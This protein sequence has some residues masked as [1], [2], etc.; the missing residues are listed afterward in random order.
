MD[1]GEWIL[2]NSNIFSSQF[3]LD[4]NHMSS[5]LEETVPE[6]YMYPLFSIL[7]N[8][9]LHMDTCNTDNNHNT[10]AMSIRES[11]ECNN[12]DSNNNLDFIHK[13]QKQ[14]DIISL[15]QSSIYKTKSIESLSNPSLSDSKDYQITKIREKAHQICTLLPIYKYDRVF[16]I[17]Y[18]NRYAENYIEL[19][20]WD[21]LPMKRP[22]IKIS[23]NMKFVDDNSVKCE[24][25]FYVYGR[26]RTSSMKQI[27]DLLSMQ[28][29]SNN[30]NTKSK[31]TVL[32]TR[33]TGN[34][35][36]NFGQLLHN[37][38]QYLS[39]RENIKK[40]KLSAIYK[41]K[42]LK[43]PTKMLEISNVDLSNIKPYRVNFSDSSS[44]NKR[45]VNKTIIS[46]KNTSP[47]IS[48]RSKSTLCD[49]VTSDVSVAVTKSQ[50]S[51]ENIE[52][53]PSTSTGIYS[54]QNTKHVFGGTRKKDIK[55]LK[56]TS[57]SKKD[58]DIENTRIPL[59]MELDKRLEFIFPDLDKN[60]IN[61]LCIRYS[62]TDLSLD[63]QFEE[64]INII[65]EDRQV[66]PVEI[67]SKINQEKDYDIDE[68]YNYL[69]E[70]FPNA[71]PAYLKKV[72][73][74]TANDPAKL[75]QFIEDQC[76]CPTY[77]TKDE[78]I[79]RMHI[80]EQQMLY[81]R[82]FDVRQ[83]LEIYPSPHTYFEDPERK[84]E[85]NPDALEFLKHHFNKFEVETLM[86]VYEQHNYH[87]TITANALENMK[88]DKKTNYTTMWDK[89]LSDDIS[90]LHECAFI[91]HKN[92]ITEYQKELKKREDEEFEELQKRNELLICQCCYVNCIPSKCSTCDDG[93]VFCN[94]CIVRGTQTQIA[95]GN[96][97]VPCFV[98]CD[99][100]F[101]L[102]TLQKVLTPMQFSIFVRKMQEREVMSAGI[103]GLVSCPFCQFASIPPL[104]DNVFKCLNPECMK[105]SCRLCKEI[106]HI[107]LKCYEEK[108]EKARLFLEEKMTE[109]LVH[110]CHR[111]S[112]PYFKENGCN[113]ITCVCGC[114]M[115][116]LCD[117]EITG[118]EHF[119]K[120]ICS[121][122]SD[123][124]SLNAAAV[125]AVAEKTMKYIEEKD[126][127]IKINADIIFPN[128][129]YNYSEA[130]NQ[131]IQKR[132]DN[133]TR[134]A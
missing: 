62:N 34:N 43:N 50:D 111:C 126:P 83:F 89:T 4:N 63:K 37:Y 85:Y 13:S 52:V 128:I 90:L 132:V 106:N 38:M 48:P 6:S 82:E 28:Y 96:V 59:R 120:G 78:K 134:F 2:S 67:N 47:D 74:R 46:S 17:L 55:F 35:S 5:S 44:T 18:K 97:H 131:L 121:L 91:K 129:Q 9:E 119:N 57:E 84:H 101:R 30:S 81:I 70:I 80:T 98:D 99:G 66:C 79:R 29:S 65:V 87:L 88:P 130:N 86:N 51:L 104:R 49:T 19:S 41:Q 12:N 125:Q 93:H 110:K 105:E 60:Y 11:L 40:Q 133:I 108:T 54:T 109:A 68:K 20:L 116:Y 127:N 107:P 1:V 117:E 112:R 25:I 56:R 58:I 72:I 8:V 73:V 122:T 75:D 113:K 42:Q 100:E 114:M 77:L 26:K 71:E 39:S 103:L 94:S 69:K 23:S 3:D 115:C 45:N 24:E 27:N 95:Q 21:L 7:T 102:S 10:Y 53:K 32:Q 124:H 14:T 15:S 33:Y 76:K 16:E 61:K 123:D 64:L 31:E 92:R 118:Y 22:A 36:K